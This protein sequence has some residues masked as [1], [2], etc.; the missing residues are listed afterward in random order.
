MGE[1]NRMNGVLAE[2][3][4]DMGRRAAAAVTVIETVRDD[5]P[6]G[7]E[8]D[9]D[10]EAVVLA[11]P[12][13]LDRVTFN[14]AGKVTVRLLAVKPKGGGYQPDYYYVPPPLQK[15]IAG[16]LRAFW[17]VPYYNHTA[18]S[19]GLYVAKAPKESEL[20]NNRYGRR[21]AK[22]F[23]ESAEWHAR[24]TVRIWA[25]TDSGTY[26]IKTEG[27]DQPVTFPARPT[28]ELL[29]EALGP[30]RFITDVSH[31]VYQEVI[32]GEDY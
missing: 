29:A 14:A 4:D 26:H 30:T 21:L 19:L 32:A 6:V 17:V 1:T 25:D 13:P 28:A 23:A 11:K 24:R 10:G 18:R 22:L 8:D 27:L 12:E 31:P 16:F 20:K 7:D 9:Y 2:A 15:G 3:V 5:S